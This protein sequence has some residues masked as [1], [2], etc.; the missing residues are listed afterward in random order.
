MNKEQKSETLRGHRHVTCLIKVTAT[1]PPQNP[2]VSMFL[3]RSSSISL[4]E[5]KKWFSHEVQD[6]CCLSSSCMETFCCDI[7]IVVESFGR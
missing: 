7:L 1:L 3:A 4:K 6:K 2:S 5:L